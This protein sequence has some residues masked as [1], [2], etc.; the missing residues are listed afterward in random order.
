M[1]AVYKEGYI[2][3]PPVGAGSKPALASIYGDNSIVWVL[4][5]Q[6]SFVEDA[7]QDSTLAG[8]LKAYLT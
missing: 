2:V 3:Q 1:G 5:R 8:S 6:T 7:A 4:F